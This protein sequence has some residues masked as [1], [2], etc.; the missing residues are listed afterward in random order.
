MHDHTRRPF[1]HIAGA[2]IRGRVGHGYVLAVAGAA[3]AA[4]AAA[5]A[6][7][8][9]GLVDPA[10]VLLLGVLLVAARTHAGPAVLAAVLCFLCYNVFFI[11]PRY[12]LHIG[13]PQGM[14]TAALFLAAALLTGRLASRLGMQVQ[15]LRAANAQARA[16]QEL[17]WRLV[18]AASV[19]EVLAAAQDAFRQHL[20]G[21]VWV[22]FDDRALQT[23][24]FESPAGA[25]GDLIEALPALQAGEPVETTGWWLLAVRLPVGSRCVIGLRLHAG[26]ERLEGALSPL[27]RALSEDIAQALLRT[28]LAADLE[29][30]RVAHET[31]RLRSVLLAS[32]S[33]D[34]RT[35]LS[36][37][38]GAAESLDSY[39][40]SMDQSDR[41]SLLATI[42]EEGQ[43]L[44]R[45]IQN[46]LDMTRLGHE[47]LPL[48]RDWIGVDELIGSAVDRTRRYRPSA[49]FELAIDSDIGPI[50]VHPALLEQALF[51]VIE[52]A[53]TY[54][55][56]GEAVRVEARLL[57]RD[58][59]QI[60]VHD[61]GP[62]IPEGERQR[63]FD[64][65][66]S[67]ARGD[68]GRGGTGLGLAI[69][70]GMIGA[71]GGE[72]EALTGPDGSGTTLR[73]T[74]PLIAGMPL[75]EQP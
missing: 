40:G 59:L 29:A 23:V 26:S 66:Y 25:T 44:D 32:V 48:H 71:H 69:C 37:I 73:I 21:D 3:A 64:M 49:R 65:F 4:I 1:E 51:N 30:E 46:L 45:Y 67:V 68:R 50:W 11:E 18:A 62:G 72:V 12:S 53:V 34:L 10:L 63:I 28:R 58:R 54:S 43:R 27:A 24:A 9:L 33:H 7:R 8:W 52:N 17:G 20:G 19:E 2:R 57:A 6:E 61:R 47:A 13:T 22:Q 39:G 31:E 70:R 55:P 75:P 35:P 16:R 15:A 56:P 74:L 14:A 41:S 38:I 42:R 60:Q 36:G 5:V